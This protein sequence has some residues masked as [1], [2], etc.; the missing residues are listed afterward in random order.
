MANF[1]YGLSLDPL[2]APQRHCFYD[3]DEGEDEH[4]SIPEDLYSVVVSKKISAKLLLVGTSETACHFLSSHVA[5]ES[6]PFA[7]VK[8]RHPLTVLKGK[9][10]TREGEQVDTVA[11]ED[12]VVLSK[13][14]RAIGGQEDVCVCL[15]EDALK[16]S[17]CNYWSR[18]VRG[19]VCLVHVGWL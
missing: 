4:E 1:Q 11:E 2:D 10:F 3:S 19:G 17:Y 15:N 16:R 8:T 9:Y 6:E 14:H 13:I 12:E 7:V 18:K 5:M